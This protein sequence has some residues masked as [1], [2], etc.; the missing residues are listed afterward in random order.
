MRFYLARVSFLGVSFPS[1]Y[2]PCIYLLINIHL[3]NSNIVHG[4]SAILSNA[5]QSYQNGI[6]TMEGYYSL[7]ALF[8]SYPS[9]LYSLH[10]L[11]NPT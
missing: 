11:S 10:Y 3:H 8:V 6:I 9:F 5:I 2:I 1:T 7:D 4:F